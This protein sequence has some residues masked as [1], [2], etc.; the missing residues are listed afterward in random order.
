MFCRECFQ[1]AEV[2][3]QKQE[4]LLAGR[5]PSTSDGGEPSASEDKKG[6]VERGED[7]VDESDSSS[8]SDLDDLEMDWRAKHS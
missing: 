5:A 1:K 8:C 2:L 7:S 3:R 6:E 4:A